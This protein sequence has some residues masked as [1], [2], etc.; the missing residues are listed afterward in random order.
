VVTED[1]AG[2]DRRAPVTRERVL[3]AAVALADEGGLDAVSMRK[4]GQRLG[5]EAMA[6]Y[7]HVRDKEDLLDGLA[8]VVLGEIEPPPPGG[9]WKAGLRGQILAARSVMLRHP[10]APRLLEDRGTSGPAALEHIE[11]VLATLFAGGFSIDL[12]HHAM[13]VL[14]SRVFGFNQD[15]FDDSGVPDPETA[16][17]FAAQLASAYP[18]IAAIAGAASHE[19]GLGGCDD[20]YEFAFGL[21]LILDGLERRRVS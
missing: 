3:E 15:L 11:R 7:R 19:G 12:A 2:A 18:N 13:H 5:V 10:W 20:D 16:A 6:M 21:D 8:E 14:G 1:L 17:A 9:D 4:L